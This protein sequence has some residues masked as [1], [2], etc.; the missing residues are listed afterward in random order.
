MCIV[1]DESID[2]IKD[3]FSPTEILKNK[4]THNCKN[5][6]DSVCCN[7]GKDKIVVCPCFYE[8]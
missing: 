3:N 8:I 2:K 5:C 4:N 6:A 7:R 1:N